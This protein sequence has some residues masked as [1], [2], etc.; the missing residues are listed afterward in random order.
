MTDPPVGERLL[1]GGADVAL[2][3][4]R[5][6]SLGDTPEWKPAPD[7]DWSVASG[8]GV[9]LARIAAR[10]V[11][12]LGQRFARAVDKRDLAFLS[13][14]GVRLVPPRPSVAP[15][16]FHLADKA[17]DGRVPDGTRLTAAAPP[18][19]SSPLAFETESTVAVSSARLAEVVSFWPG[20]DQYID[21]SAALASAQ[22]FHPFR[23][24]ELVD[25]PHALYLAHDRLLALTGKVSLSVGIEFLTQ[26]NSPLSIVWEY[27]D[28]KVWRAFKDPSPPC[29]RSTSPGKDFTQGFT[30]NG[31]VLLETDFAE[32]GEATIS[33]VKSHWVRARLDTPLPAGG[34][35]SLTKSP[36]RETL[37]EVVEAERIL[38]EIDVID[39]SL[40]IQRPLPPLLP[41][42]NPRH[43]APAPDRDALDPIAGK[44]VPDLGLPLDRAFADRLAFDVSKTFFPFGAQ[45]QPG[46]TFY[47]MLEEVMV[48]PGA[49]VTLDFKR[50][51]TPQHR[52]IE[53]LP[54]G[55]DPQPGVTFD[56]TLESLDAT[57][58]WEYWDGRNWS[59]LDLAPDTP[60][61]ANFPRRSNNQFQWADLFLPSDF[62]A[63]R[64]VPLGPMRVSFRVPTDVEAT[65][66]NN[67]Q[68]RWLR[69]RLVNGGFGATYKVTAT[70]GRGVASTTVAVYNDPP[71]LEDLRAGYV[72]QYGPFPPE[73]VFTYNDFQYS[74]ETDAAHWEGQTFPP[75][76]PPAETSP[77]LYLGFDK[78]QPQ[79][80][81]GIYF[82]VK[83]VPL[84][85][86]GPAL[87]WEYWNGFDWKELLSVD[88]HTR[89]L[90]VPGLVNLLGP[91]DSAPL[92]RFGTPRHW[93]RARLREDGPP[94]EPTLSAIVPNAVDCVQRETVTNEPLG[95]SDG[96]PNLTL[97]FRRVPVL[98]E[99]WVEVRESAGASASVEWRI[100][101]REVGGGSES[102]IRDLEAKLAIEGTT[103]D[104]ESGGV[105][106]KR[107]RLKKVTEVWVTWESR[108]HLLESGPADRHYVVERSRGT[109]SFGDGVRGK[110]PP[111]ASPVQA[112]TYRTGGGSNGNVPKGAINQVMAS[113]SGLDKA[114]NLRAAEGGA[115]GET[116]SQ[117]RARGPEALRNRGRAL[118][119]SDYEELAREASPS[120]AR[121]W[122][123]SE[124]DGSGRFAPRPGGVTL[125]VLPRTDPSDPAPWPTFGL[126][127]EVRLYL[128]DRAPASLAGSGRIKVTG[129]TYFPIDI[130]A[131]LAPVHADDAGALIDKAKGVLATFLHPVVGGRDGTGW[132]PEAPLHA[133]DVATALATIDLL[134]HVESLVLLVDGS[135]RGDVVNVPVGR[136]ICMGKVSLKLAPAALLEGQSS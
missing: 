117:A 122:A 108:P 37:A 22:E 121:A 27:W 45:P 25:T 69:V 65:K 112:R 42:A 133:S 91:A 56:R 3:E 77:A 72:W 62:Q 23:K 96:Q 104:P 111:A 47:W 82:D 40:Q 50:A 128:V 53:V 14:A 44:V 20:R 64:T 13:L 98:D 95:I 1:T 24:S 86:Q 130:E 114:E 75:F 83:E 29:N 113:I 51:I 73:R 110:I 136:L 31:P 63:V 81:L 10:Y 2:A 94:G 118:L 7:G 57:L 12:V 79:D 5:A 125:Q 4:I 6:R 80:R 68:G 129:P 71:A 131:T 17:P 66:V 52:M 9:A 99:E 76:R 74:D 35:L 103:L 119:P 28:G 49:V 32:T 16:S 54:Q 123:S 33:G 115:D 19:S 101:A 124:R 70:T 107:D 55:N 89:A 109:V 78:A 127:E 120:V 34:S 88:D 90:R 8:P 26:G 100:I 61:A 105:R 39:L 43:V 92:P 46:A 97:N 135:A 134:D 126:R 85:D 11:E 15:V 132:L 93:L 67:V 102:M 18:G 30:R 84:E 21:H 106:L 60:G 36:G 38:P 48:K 116:L 87:A 59:A 41:P 58:A